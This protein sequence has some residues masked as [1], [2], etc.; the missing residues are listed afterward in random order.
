ISTILEVQ[1]SVATRLHVLHLSTRDGVR[2]IRDAKHDGRPVTSEANPFAM[3]ITNNWDLIE[4]K[5]PYPLG[6]WVPE[7]DNPAMWEAVEDG[8]IDVIGSDHGPHAR[9]EKEIG[10]SDMY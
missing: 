2:M 6:F 9:E 10:W 1:R 5:G 7:A 4:Q 3:F 8:T